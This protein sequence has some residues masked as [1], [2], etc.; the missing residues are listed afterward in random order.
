MAKSWCTLENTKW[1]IAA[2]FCLSCLHQITRFFD[3]E[4]EAVVLEIPLCSGDLVEVAKVT[5]ATWVSDG[6]DGSLDAY[7]ISFFGFRIIFVHL[8]PCVSLVTFNIMLFRAMKEAEK[9]RERLLSGQPNRHCKV[10]RG[11]DTKD[12]KKIRDANRTTHMLIV[13]ITVFLAVELPL[14]IIVTFHTV[15]SSLHANFLNYEVMAIMIMFLNMIIALSYP[16]NFGIYCGMSQ[17]F[18]ETFMKL[19]GPWIPNMPKCCCQCKREN[20]SHT[21]LDAETNG[22]GGMTTHATTIRPTSLRA[23]L[24][25]IE[26]G[27]GTVQLQAIP[28]IEMDKAQ[29]ACAGDDETPVSVEVHAATTKESANGILFSN[30]TNGTEPLVNSTNG[31]AHETHL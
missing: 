16:L 6:S 8:L 5:F 15:A 27:K 22:A 25:S 10:N 20:D 12:S 17:Q 29:E 9:R 26:N 23:A 31:Q 2:I 1:G 28:M 21:S 13:V 7:M 14:G 24:T 30:D 18:R 19:F 4:Y 3:K 11:G